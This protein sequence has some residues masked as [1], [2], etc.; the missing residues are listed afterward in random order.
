MRFSTGSLPGCACVAT[1]R[2]TEG[3]LGLVG[4]V[5]NLVAWIGA[6]VVERVE[7]R[8]PVPYLMR[9]CVALVVRFDVAARH[10][11]GEDDDPNPTA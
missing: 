3:G 4:S 1:E 7:Q 5:P 11:A 10:G 9:G 6:S 2:A 8:Q